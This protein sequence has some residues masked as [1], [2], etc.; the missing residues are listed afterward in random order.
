M[1]GVTRFRFTWYK[2]D[3]VTEEPPIDDKKKTQLHD[4]ARLYLQIK[5]SIASDVGLDRLVDHCDSVK[6]SQS[7]DLLYSWERTSSSDV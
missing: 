1:I 4:D 7:F 6:S 5:S 2:Y 3:R